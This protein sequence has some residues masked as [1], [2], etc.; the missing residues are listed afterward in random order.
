[1]EGEE[2]EGDPGYGLVMPPEAE[3]LEEGAVVGDDLVVGAAVVFV[4]VEGEGDNET[5][6]FLLC[7]RGELVLPASLRCI[8][9]VCGPSSSSVG[10]FCSIVYLYY[11]KKIT[12]RMLY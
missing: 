8:R 2:S 3:S 12:H 4:V 10:N 7:L 11:T 9:G 6:G 1:M 5:E